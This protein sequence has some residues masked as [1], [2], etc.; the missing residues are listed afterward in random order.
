M[1]LDRKRRPVWEL[2]R[3]RPAGLPEWTLIQNPDGWAGDFPAAYRNPHWQDI[4]IYGASA[5][6]HPDRDYFSAV[7]ELIRDGFDCIYMDWMEFFEDEAVIAEA[8][9]DRSGPAEEMVKFIGRIR[10]YAKER[11]PDFLIIQQNGSSLLS[12]Q[13]QLLQVIDA[14]AHEGVWHEN[15]SDMDWNDPD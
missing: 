9:K 15:L 5:S 10:Q 3:P 6:A 1:V 13:P 14:I 7:D 8:S 2:G 12:G 4:M 11:D